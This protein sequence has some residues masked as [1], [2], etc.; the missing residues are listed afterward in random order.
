MYQERI[1]QTTPSS[2]FGLSNVVNSGIRAVLVY[3]YLYAKVVLGAFYGK[4]F[5][6]GERAPDIEIQ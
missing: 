5:A 4:I 1:D 2:R 6:F 3:Y